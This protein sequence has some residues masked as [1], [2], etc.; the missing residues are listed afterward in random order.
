MPGK[1]LS[2]MSS[3]AETPFSSCWLK[4]G[5]TPVTLKGSSLSPTVFMWCSQ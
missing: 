2:V 1:E 4:P 3:K 5:L